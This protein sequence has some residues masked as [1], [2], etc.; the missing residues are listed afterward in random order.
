[1]NRLTSDPPS[2]PDAVNGRF[3]RRSQETLMF[4]GDR[5]TY[6]TYTLQGLEKYL[7][8]TRDATS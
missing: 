4:T 3:L 2:S 8:V 6:R 1:M 5:S 7:K